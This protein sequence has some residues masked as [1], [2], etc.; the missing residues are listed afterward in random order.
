MVL[1]A[2]GLL[3]ACSGSSDPA[4][5]DDVERTC[6]LLTIEKN[7]VLPPPA[8]G[9]V[10]RSI[11][12]SFAAGSEVAYDASLSID[13]EHVGDLEQLAEEVDALDGVDVAE[14]VGQEAAYDELREILA[15]NPTL[16][17]T[18]E[19]VDLPASI[20]VDVTT[21]EALDALATWA[22][23]DAR[24]GE[25]GDV[26]DTA[27]TMFASIARSFGDELDELEGMTEGRLRAAVEAIRA[28]DALE[29]GDVAQTFAV[30][31]AF[32]VERCDDG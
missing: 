5:T 8:M 13:P 11:S 14:V 19:A 16:L 27:S 21:D 20:R 1:G 28:P 4:L 25:V 26:R 9:A 32:L 17:D 30:I 23:A 18:I 15:E 2:C 3:A 29:V 12:S 6:E 22:A 24:I 7:L 31:S 10:P